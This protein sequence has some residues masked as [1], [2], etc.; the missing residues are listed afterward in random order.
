MSQRLAFSRFIGHN[1]IMIK[2]D[3][4]FAA[5]V[6]FEIIAIL[7]A[8]FGIWIAYTNDNI[9]VSYYDVKDDLIPDEFDG[10][11]IAHV[12]DLHNRDWD[13]RAEDLIAAE[14]P[15]IVVV[16]GDMVDSS[17]R[18][19]DNSLNFLKEAVKIAPVYYVSGNHE[20]NMTDYDSLEKSFENAGATVLN[21]ENAVLQ[22]NGS[23]INLIGLRD[24]AFE[25]EYASDNT[26]K[27]HI[28]DVI[29]SLSKE[30]IFNIVLSHRPEYF[31]VY[32][33]TN[34]DLVLCGHAHG[35][36][37]RIGNKGI[38]A[39]G[40]G[41][42]PEYTAGIHEKNDTFMIVSRG[43]GDSVLPRVNNMPELVFVT[44]KS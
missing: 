9:E 42:F 11:K 28:A 1:L 39:P 5:I 33:L 34:A 27:E 32:A 43:L 6:T 36:Q 30:G 31:D 7:F 15:D 2:R 21:D 41:F 14:K 25:F 18:Y 8:A 20:A 4:A 17:D 12:S 19:F 16:T 13:G 40:Q 35:G 22:K 26:V 10:F 29:N 44:L 37:I 24:P 3:K 23:Q 38:F